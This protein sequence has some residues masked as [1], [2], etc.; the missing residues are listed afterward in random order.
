MANRR[1]K[2]KMLS[3]F[4]SKYNITLFYKPSYKDNDMMYVIILDDILQL[5]FK[6]AGNVII[7]DEVKPLVDDYIDFSKELITF[8]LNQTS[9]NIL[10]SKLGN[11]P[12]INKLC[13]E[14]NV[15]VVD[16]ERFITVPLPLYKKYIDYYKGN[17]EAYG[18]YLLAVLDDIVVESETSDDNSEDVTEEETMD[19]N[20]TEDDE[21]IDDEPIAKTPAE[22]K[23]CLMDELMEM[24]KSGKCSINSS[25]EYDINVSLTSEIDMILSTGSNVIEI[26]DIVFSASSS[27]TSLL[28]FVQ[29]IMSKFN[30]TITISI[31]TSANNKNVI[32]LCDILDFVPDKSHRGGVRYVK[33]P[34]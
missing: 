29:D 16:D 11:N 22:L 25:T 23:N 2:D 24:S 27:S 6:N 14:L 34:E 17:S 19:N 3:F 33:Q 18:F 20:I 30:D 9:F 15:P 10:I 12:A 31:V 8:F 1:K 5:R 4:K 13:S 7:M 21:V 32:S 26:S 28:M